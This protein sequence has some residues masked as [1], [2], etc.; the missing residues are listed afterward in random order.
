MKNQNDLIF[1]LGAAFVLIVV[2]CVC[3]FTRPQPTAPAAPDEVNL[4]RPVLPSNVQPIMANSLPSSGSN[5]GVGGGGGG[6][7][8]SMGGP[9]P[10]A[11]AGGG[12]GAI[13]T[14][15]MSKGAAGASV[16]GH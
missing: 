14:M 12:E 13:G 9:S 2:A 16:A 15:S 8:G 6:P 1:S 10:A 5:N 7:R 11:G 4:T 3:Y